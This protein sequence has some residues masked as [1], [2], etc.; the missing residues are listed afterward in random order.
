MFFVSHML[1]IAS[2]IC[3]VSIRTSIYN[4][5]LA[6]RKLEGK[7]MG[8]KNKKKKKEKAASLDFYDP[9]AGTS[10]L[11]SQHEN[12]VRAGNRIPERM[13][14][15]LYADSG[16]FFGMKSERNVYIGKPSSEDGHILVV[17][18]PGSYKTSGI[19]HP[20]LMTW[21][22]SQIIIDVKGDLLKYWMQ[23]NKH[24]GKKIKIFSAERENGCFYDPFAFLRHGGKENI[25]ANSLDLALALIPL[26]PD[27]KDPIWINTA[28]NYLTGAIIYF[29]D[30]G[31]NFIGT[32][33]YVLSKPV[34]DIITE[35]MDSENIAAKIFM[36]KFV[37][38]PET[39]IDG[40]GMELSELA[41][42]ATDPA[43]ERSFSGEGEGGYIDWAELNTAKE[44]FDIMLVL[45][46]AN[47]ER[48]EPMIALMLNQ[49]IKSLERRPHRTY[50]KATGLPPILIML[51][52][53]P[54]LGKVSSITHGL[55]TLRSRGVT[56]ALFVQSLAQLDEIYGEKNRRIIT[57]LC[58]Y[59]AIL[60]VTDA[61]NQ[62]YF[63][64]LIGTIAS[65]QRG[66]SANHDPYTG[67][68]IGFS[69]QINES[70]EPI[71]H[72]HELATLKDIIL[73]IPD[74]GFCR[75][76]KMPFF[77]NSG[78]FL[79]AQLLKNRSCSPENILGGFSYS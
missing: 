16:I 29:F 48:W 78:L 3:L 21:Q 30:L 10:E 77:C 2:I 39:T 58:D 27:V 8:K 14:L 79:R 60:K 26:P 7:K 75:V 44:P 71:I 63:S 11:L 18:G 6:K 45:P 61:E 67:E 68:I 59:K 53:F 46:E 32:I 36:N 17:G 74:I 70:R 37:D 51:D 42:F 19:V 43:I 35:V 64:K 4:E 28:R 41:V 34:K 5:I 9:V 23:C 25:V 1:E 49:L 40:I 12:L 31:V 15:D 54:R 76:Q 24:T 52:E 57:D 47:L 73:L 66:I 50:N 33:T 56:F 62:E 72:P 55:S 65:A 20:T 69:R 22:G 13:K 38:V